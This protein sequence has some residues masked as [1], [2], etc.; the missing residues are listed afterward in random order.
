[1]MKYKVLYALLICFSVT[2]FAE[3]IGHGSSIYR[4]RNVH[5]GNLVRV[6]FHNHCMMGGISGDQSV[7]YA[8]E[9]PIGTGQIQMGN[10]S[11]YVMSE[12]RIPAG[13]DS[14]TG[15]T[16]YT[17]VNPAVFCQ[18][19]DPNAFSHDSLG[20]FLGFEPLPG[21]YNIAQQEKDPFHAV[22][23]NHQAFTWP[24]FWPDKQEDTKDPGWSGSWNGY[25]GKD[26]M[27]ADEE[28]YF[29]LDDYQFKKR[30][31]GLALPLP[32]AS[33][34][35]RGGLGL[36]LAARGLQWSNP[37]AEDCIFWLYEIRNFGELNLSKTLFGINVGASS[38]ALLGENTDY[39]DDVASFYREKALAVN[40]DYDNSGTR[41][42]SPVPWVGFAFL[43]SPGNPYDGI[44]NDGDG[45]EFGGGKIITQE[46]FLK[47][48]SVGE[49]VVV[50]DYFSDNYD[51]S[52]VPMP[53]EGIS[54]TLNGITYHKKPG[55]PLEEIPRNLI[56]DNLN[57]L[58]DESDGAVTQDSVEYYLY[59]RSEYNDQ[60][61]LAVDYVSGE[62]LDNL[63]IDERRDD[64]IDNDED[65]NADFDDVGLDGKPGTGDT[66]EGD[67]QPT[68]GYGNLPGEPSID[69]VDVNESDQIGLTSFK[70]YQYGDV[71]YSNDEQ[72]W[73]I[74]RPGYFDKE[75]TEIADY[76]YV[77]SCGYFPL[78]SMQEEFLSVAMVYGLDETDILRNKDVIQK[79]YDSNYNFAIA[80]TKPNL[81]IVAGDQ[82]AT[83]YWD[84]TAEYSFDRFLKAYDF[85][86]Y[87]IYKATH[88]TFEDAGYITDG[89][90]YE[91]FKTP[92]AIYDK[93][94][95]LFGYFPNDFGTGILFNLGNE[96]GLV[97][98]Y[99]DSPLTNGVKYY[100]AVTAYDKGDLDKNIGP[101]ETTI[102]LNVDPSGNIQFAQNVA[103]VIPQAPSLG[104]E[105]AGFDE[106]PQPVGEGITTGRVGVR[107]L[108]PDSLIDGEEYEIQFLDQS[109]D[110]M[111]NDFDGL[112]DGED[113]DEVL[114]V[115]TTGFVLKNLTQS[116]ILDTV[117]FWSYKNL[118]DSTRVM[119]A[120]LYEDRDGNPR[121]L[122]K[123][124]HHMEFF[125]YNPPPG[126][127]TLPELNVFNGIQ[128]SRNIM[129]A[130]AYN[131]IFDKFRLG[132]FREGISYPRQYEIIFYDEI[133]QKSE[134]IGV[135]LAST[136]T[137][138]PLPAA[139][140]NFR[141]YDPQSGEELKFGM[142][143]AS[144]DPDITPP[145]FFSA[146]DR[147]LFFEDLPDGSR[148]ITFNLLNNDVQDTSFVNVYG[149]ILG[150]GD[151]L[152]LVPDFPF[153]GNVRYR[154][155]VRG[156]KIDTEEAKESLD[157]I[158][159]V[160]NPYVVTA[161]WEPHNPYTTGR[162]P[163]QV[164]FIHLP[165]E[166]TIRIYTVDG[167]LVQTLRH[168]SSMTDGSVS[169]DLMTREN[170]DIAYGIY[171]YH[172]EAP[173]VGEHVGRFLVIK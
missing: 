128:W 148:A 79:I 126:V 11:V 41:Q 130:T 49:D 166:C 100:Y 101:S 127:I 58:I 28:S 45:M 71:T 78:I 48:Y 61:Y 21:Y 123:I 14:V 51:R 111:D 104:Y 134:Q 154:F 108:D 109:M 19:W 42:Y 50:I 92:V 86:G 9:W 125:V 129:Y 142:V 59:I 137:L 164:Q 17:M 150:A 112:I 133:V 145:G 33:E 106:E 94:D 70:F 113:I 99:V 37:D 30:M 117:P 163:R 26:Q 139:D 76:D 6:T 102:F 69:Q 72:M 7:V 151:T 74:S 24:P 52:V 36:R 121:T 170:M 90:G 66:G 149:R 110:N 136:G 138:Y 5:A 119:I 65:W 62:G 169:W 171:I 147:I 172:I 15:D 95:S 27:N 73:D 158:R 167:T 10:T 47:F 165:R 53:E 153:T 16:L 67:K 40:Y 8:G 98:T 132:G 4:T 107:F 12:L 105:A 89:L 18:G 13:T 80:P 55:A 168:E 157:R 60:D 25:F 159:V 143:D 85:E 161:L 141:V 124:L 173:G 115:K 116:A 118:N 160:P 82:K 77:F 156:H 20:T 88:H 140:V 23:M 96:T 3:E 1:M 54:F 122:T 57:G 31:R 152:R 144:V 162:G 43:E 84:D 135:P 83:L 32:V 29:V 75:S 64:G 22:A 93:V 87:K 34:P 63:M 2:G 103:A 35:D 81:R 38:G 91:R 97:H 68:A 46:D 120:D 56:D 114:P 155:K 39:N 131:L 44:D 146:K